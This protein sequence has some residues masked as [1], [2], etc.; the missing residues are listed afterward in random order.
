M[1]P[2][3]DTRILLIFLG[4]WYVRCQRLSLTSGTL[5]KCFLGFSRILRLDRDF[6]G[7]K[8]IFLDLLQTVK[9]TLAASYLTA[10]DVV[11]FV[12]RCDT[13]QS[14]LQELNAVILTSGLRLELT[15][16]KMSYAGIHFPYQ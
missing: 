8:D 5:K 10:G 2:D 15:V 16:L 4:F 11:L 13:R 3:S 1:L 12:G 7:I 14:T 6:Q 9:G